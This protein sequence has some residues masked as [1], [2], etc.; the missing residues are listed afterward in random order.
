[1]IQRAKTEASE[2]ERELNDLRWATVIRGA[3]GRQT[4]STDSHTSEFRRILNASVANLLQ[5]QSQP[6]T[7]A[8]GSRSGAPTASTSRSD[9]VPAYRQANSTAAL[10]QSVLAAASTSPPH[11]GPSAGPTARSSDSDKHSHHS[12]QSH[13][14]QQPEVIPTTVQAMTPLGQ[15]ADSVVYKMSG[16]TGEPTTPQDRQRAMYSPYSSTGIYADQRYGQRYVAPVDSPSAPGF[17][18]SGLQSPE[19]A[20]IPGYSRGDAARRGAPLVSR[21]EAVYAA[22][23]VVPNSNDPAKGGAHPYPASSSQFLQ[24]RMT[25]ASHAPTAV[26]TERAQY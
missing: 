5:P 23:R 1:M 11:A 17:T 21:A 13:R 12:Q 19:V 26:R 9:S 18:R 24:T 20:G 22:S 7:G 3:D 10:R 16:M 6:G 25:G 15:V 8:G 2:Y 4:A 14:S